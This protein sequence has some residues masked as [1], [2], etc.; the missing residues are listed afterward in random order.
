MMKRNKRLIITEVL[1]TALMMKSN[2]SRVPNTRQKTNHDLV[3]NKQE[4]KIKNVLLYFHSRINK[5]P[6]EER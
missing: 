5:C 1:C 3:N 4:T 2:K 6:L